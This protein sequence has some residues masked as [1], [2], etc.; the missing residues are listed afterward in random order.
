MT[1]GVL[2]T[3]APAPFE[4]AVSELGPP[5][6]SSP[7]AVYGEADVEV[8]VKA[9]W[10]KGALLWVLTGLAALTT[11]VLAVGWL[12]NRPDEERD[13]RPEDVAGAGAV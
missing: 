5:A 3:S 4:L 13:D 12:R 10:P 1:T 8:S 6:L 11:P 2:Y 7:S 9:P